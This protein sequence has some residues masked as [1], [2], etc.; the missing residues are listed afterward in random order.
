VFRSR[1]RFPRFPRFSLLL[2]LF[3]LAG[4]SA[5]PFLLVTRAPASSR[6]RPIDRK[7]RACQAELKDL[8]A[9]IADVD[10]LL[11]KAR[12]GDIFIRRTSTGN[13]N[14]VDVNAVFHY[15][16]VVF[17]L[18]VG[19]PFFITQLNAIYPGLNL[20]P[21]ADLAE[22]SQALADYYALK[23][24]ESAKALT[25]V[26][27]EL[28]Q[29]V[30]KTAA[31]CS[32]LSKQGNPPP[33]PKP[34]KPPPAAGSF[35][36]TSPVKVDPPQKR[37]WTVNAGADGR[38]TWNHPRD[39]G[40]WDV[41]YTFQ[42]PEALSPGHSYPIKLSINVTSVS[43]G[44][45][46]SFAIGVRNEGIVERDPNLAVT[47]S[48][49]TGGPISKTLT[50]HVPES[51]KDAPASFNPSIYVGIQDGFGVTYTYHRAGA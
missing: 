38:A 2:F 15:G 26:R 6:E 41:E 24:R 8:R 25:A 27:E 12:N 5:I 30:R 17:T 43:S 28:L 1:F 33:K 21:R 44:G 49:A 36:L 40:Q 34:P 48:A 46:V 51:Y 42:V 45:P 23:S 20:N 32:A 3:V 18:A 50:L 13:F 35:V 16:R 9:V 39:G 11:K 31:R 47:V 7:I 10:F 37:E 29:K 19:K 14:V 4:A 22:F